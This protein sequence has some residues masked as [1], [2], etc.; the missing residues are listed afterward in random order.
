M[1]VALR[2]KKVQTA[3]RV[4]Q[5]IQD[6][7]EDLA[8]QVSV[9]IQEALDKAVPVRTIIG[10]R[11]DIRGDAIALPDVGTWVPMDGRTIVDTDSVLNGVTLEDL[12][13]GGHF[14]RGGDVAGVLQAADTLVPA[15][16]H[17]KGTL[18]FAG[19]AMGTHQHH[20]PLTTSGGAFIGPSTLGSTSQQNGLT[21][22]VSAGTPTGTITG[23]TANDGGSGVETR[24]VNC[25]VQYF[26]RIK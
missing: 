6:S 9:R 12:N 11:T 19:N 10:I 25:S 24:P 26:I 13:G 14:L 7:M 8:R 2:V 16:T 18:A 4:L 21:E 23:S 1:S 5:Q 15:H 17:A 22:A 20:I 3:D